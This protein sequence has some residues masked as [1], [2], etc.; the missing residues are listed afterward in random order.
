MEG[1]VDY[2][3]RKLVTE[4]GGVD[5]CVTEFIRVTEQLL[6]RKEFLKHAP[7]LYEGGRTSA[8]IPV[9][10]QLLGSDPEALAMNAI[11]AARMGAPSVDL[12]FGC[13]SK[14]VNKSRGGAVL[15]DEP[16][17]I[18]DIVKTVRAAVPDKVPV[19]AKMRLGNKDKT[20]A[21]EN[22]VAIEEAGANGLAIHA[23][24]KVEGY[25]PPAHWEWIARIKE[26]VNLPIVANGEVWTCDDYRRCRDI[27]GC[28]DVMIGRGL[29]ARPELGLMIKADRIGE[30]ATAAAWHE[31]LKL[32]LRYFDHVEAKL[33]A[34]YVHGRIK[35]WINMMRPQREEAE[36]LFAEIK[37]IKDLTLLRNYLVEQLEA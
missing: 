5:L 13:P 7:E 34:R 24:T 31:V 14:T 28:E 4:L 11:R 35:Q 2:T 22:A 12:N 32:L 29:I 18:H 9:A 19:T 8:A 26:Q 15:L 33:P 20:L 30:Q 37:V 10:V 3:M 23:R 17:L 6:P 16:N 21:F 1:V 27:S 25:K 36:A